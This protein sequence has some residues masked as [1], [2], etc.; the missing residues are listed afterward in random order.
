MARNLLTSTILFF[1]I[2]LSTSFL[3]AQ[4]TTSIYLQGCDDLGLQTAIEQNVSALLSEFNRACIKNENPVYNKI[5][6]DEAALAR[7]NAL[8]NTASFKCGEIELFEFVSRRTDNFMEI[9]NIPLIIQESPDSVNFEDAV[10]IVTPDGVIWDLYFGIETHQYK[11]LIR[12]NN[13]VTDFRRRQVILDFVE[14][15]RTSYNRKDLEFLE[16]IF[17]ENALIIVG[18]VI[19]VSEKQSNL[20]E[21][22][23]E[24]K[25]VELIRY[26]KSE[27]IKHLQEVFARN[28]FIKVF[29][30][31]IDL[32]QH[33]LHNNIYGVTL[34][35]KWTSSTYSDDGYLFL[36]ID[37]KDED[38][39]LIHVRAWQ[40]EAFTNPDSVI[41]LGDFEIIQ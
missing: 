6:I 9:R 3:Q 12:Q 35:Q 5:K 17:S 30:D 26:N 1:S 15:F 10:V 11:K 37:F 23:F 19:E 28:T 31:Q 21:S 4:H 40:P 36:M 2:T 18:R 16:Q 34:K 20:L 33:R 14:N 7:I 13:D 38:H 25:K 32:T 27:Y 8:W 29:F 41:S 22:N 24:K 39:P